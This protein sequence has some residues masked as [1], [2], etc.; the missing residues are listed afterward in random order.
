MGES[1]ARAALGE[2]ASVTEPQFEE[3]TALYSK[4]WG[5]PDQGIELV[6]EAVE[7]NRPFRVRSITLEGSNSF[8]GIHGLRVG[9]PE[10]EATSLLTRML[11]QGVSALEVDDADAA[12]VL[13]E[14]SYI[15]LAVR[16]MGGVVKH[17]YLGPG[18]E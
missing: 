12:G 11:G 4:Q 16:C 6:L 14:N 2:P 15:V 5:Y 18:P 10:T 17:I 3:A 1:E 8:Q 13:F 9:M 7:T